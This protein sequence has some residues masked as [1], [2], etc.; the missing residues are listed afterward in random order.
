V[1]INKVKGRGHKN[2]PV[3][4]DLKGRELEIELIKKMNA[5]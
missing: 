1:S 2:G 5:E 4:G 3:T